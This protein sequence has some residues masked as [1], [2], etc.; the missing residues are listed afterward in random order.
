MFVLVYS[1]NEQ[2]SQLEGHIV[3]GSVK[4]HSSDAC[5]CSWFASLQRLNSSV[6]TRVLR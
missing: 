6:I 1:V 5:R 4:L 2:R 3:A